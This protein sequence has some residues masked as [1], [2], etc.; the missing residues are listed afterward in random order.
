MERQGEPPRISSTYRTPKDPGR[1]WGRAHAMGPGT[2]PD[3]LGPVLTRHR[4]GGSAA[5]P[6]LSS[7]QA[8]ASPSASAPGAPASVAA[9]TSS[10]GHGASM[11]NSTAGAPFLR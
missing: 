7:D 10:K 9:V 3:T 5:R 2:L 11:R 8:A 6:S 1:G 4:P